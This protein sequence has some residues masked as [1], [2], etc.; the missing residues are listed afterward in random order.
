VPRRDP[1]DTIAPPP[2]RAGLK[3][4]RIVLKLSGEALCGEEGGFGIRP[5]T[6]QKVA[7]ELAEVQRMG[8]QIG[9]VVGG[10]NIFRGL[11]G[12]SAGMDR[13]QS[14][15]MG[16]LATVINALALQDALEKADVPTR[17][18]TA[19]EIRSIAEPYI[20]RRAIRHLEKG[21]VLIFAAGTGN[22]YFSTDTAAA[23]RAMEIQAQALFKATKV[24]GIYDRDPARFND[25]QMFNKLTYDRFLADRIGVMDSTAV[26]LCRENKM[27]IR[28]FKMTT[29][30]NILRVCMGEDI[31]TIVV[32]S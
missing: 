2:P 31:G 11:K 27:P 10:G 25:A 32:G 18:M 12:A 29:R 19:F 1:D 26:T 8:V 7:A 3:Y 30:G 23:L 22:P 13:S 17:V 20:R 9:I 14:D 28:V 15:Y 6:L 21:Y 24:E 16:M 5:D 4:R